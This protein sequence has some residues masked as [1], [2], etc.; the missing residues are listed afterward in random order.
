MSLVYSVSDEIFVDIIDAASSY[1]SCLKKLGLGTV[2][3]QSTAILKKRIKE[4]NLDTSHFKVTAGGSIPRRSFEE[5]LVE[6]STYQNR[7][8]LKRRLLASGLLEYKCY[9]CGISSWR[10]KELSLQLEH[11]NGINND[12]RIN[13][14]CL[15][16]PNCHSLTST[17]AGKNK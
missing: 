16:C 12:N 8:S 9:E 13:N 3:G 17:Y 14:L 7:A 15:L 1:S 2:G 6:N 5:I 4:L 10:G 11:K